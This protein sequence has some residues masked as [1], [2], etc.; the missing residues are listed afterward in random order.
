MS[1]ELDII[2]TLKNYGIHINYHYEIT[3][4]DS[5]VRLHILE[6]DYGPDYTR[7]KLRDTTY[8]ILDNKGFNMN[9]VGKYW[10][11]F[12]PRYTEVNR[13]G[14]SHFIIVK[15]VPYGRDDTPEESREYKLY[16]SGMDSP[17]GTKDEWLDIAETQGFSGIQV[18]EK[19]GKSK[20]YY[21]KRS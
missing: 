15:R 2:R 18:I 16:N 13:P 9:K 14:A 6:R 8:D 20:I 11:E 19:D 21:V 5:A 3:N 12:K 10:I 4:K 7:H 17:V 1:L